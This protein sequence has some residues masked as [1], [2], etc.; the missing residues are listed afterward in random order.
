MLRER[1]ESYIGIPGTNASSASLPAV[2]NGVL[3]APRRSASRR[4]RHQRDVG[5]H[6]G[7]GFGAEAKIAPAQSGRGTVPMARHE[8][9]QSGSRRRFVN[10]EF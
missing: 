10:P 9:S 6:L 5:V 3:A 4:D 7:N 2:L 8:A 1:I